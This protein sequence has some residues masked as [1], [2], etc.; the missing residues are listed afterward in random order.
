MISISSL[1]QRF[2]PRPAVLPPAPAIIPLMASQQ[3]QPTTSQ[4]QQPKHPSVEVSTS[5]FALTPLVSGARG[6][7]PQSDSTS[8]VSDP[9]LGSSNTRLMPQETAFGSLPI[10]V[11]TP[12]V[13]YLFKLPMR[14]R[15]NL[16]IFGNQV[17]LSKIL[18][19]KK[20][21]VRRL[22]EMNT[23]VER[24][25][26]V[27]ETVAPDFQ[28]RYARTILDLE[29]LNTELNSLLVKVRQQCHEVVFFLLLENLQLLF[30]NCYST[31][32]DCSRF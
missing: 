31:G 24:R 30:T 14:S 20:E 21:K 22:R 11:I 28:R 17:R 18:N 1:A 16:T 8:L 9:V 26:S 10:H 13:S 2:R 12:I 25:E 23:E 5:A 29:E 6:H 19:M 3:T 32:S 15:N 7:A 27:G 4:H